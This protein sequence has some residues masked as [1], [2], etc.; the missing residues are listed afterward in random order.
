MSGEY[1]RATA[2]GNQAHRNMT[3]RERKRLCKRTH[4][5]AWVTKRLDDG[6]KA[7]YCPICGGVRKP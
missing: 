5:G 7:I 1:G 4:W 3:L 6:T 2:G